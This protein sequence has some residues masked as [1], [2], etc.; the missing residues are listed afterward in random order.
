MDN[1]YLAV[2]GNVAVV[3][4]VVKCMYSLYIVP[5]DVWHWIEINHKFQEFQ[6]E[7]YKFL[8]NV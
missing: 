2:S 6:I 5:L 1:K 7:F 8:F 4:I 3:V